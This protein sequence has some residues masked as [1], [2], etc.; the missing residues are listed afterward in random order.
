MALISALAG[1]IGAFG[2]LIAFYLNAT[3][4]IDSQSSLYILMNLFCSLLLVGNAWISKA[5][6][7]IVINIFWVLVSANSYYT[8]LKKNKTNIS[9]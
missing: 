7:F 4:K 6:P 9:K 2:L 8:Q 3:K 5:Y 1:W